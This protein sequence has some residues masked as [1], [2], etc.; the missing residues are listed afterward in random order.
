MNKPGEPPLLDGV[1]SE[2]RVRMVDGEFEHDTETL[3]DILAALLADE[4]RDRR[5]RPRSRPE[6]QRDRAGLDP[7]LPIAP[8]PCSRLLAIAEDRLVS[9]RR[10]V[11]TG[12]GHESSRHLSGG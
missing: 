7:A 8:R 3:L 2:T 12:A 11:R 6:L 9:R 4:E 10:S 5:K 1:P